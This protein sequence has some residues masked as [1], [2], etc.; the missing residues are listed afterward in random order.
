M[1]KLAPRDPWIAHQRR[2]LVNDGGEVY[3]P[4]LACEERPDGEAVLAAFQS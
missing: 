1:T 2:D 4:I 3:V